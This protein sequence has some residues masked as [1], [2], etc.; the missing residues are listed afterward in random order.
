MSERADAGLAFMLKYENIAWY[1]G[2]AVK[3]LD[4]RVYPAR[5]EFVTCKTSGE[6]ARAIADMVTQSAGPYA[7]AGMG[8]A[9]AAYEARGKG[10]AEFNSHLEKAAH[11]LSHARPTTTGRMLAV[12]GGCLD[13]AK[14]ARASG[15]SVDEA[16]RDYTVMMND[17]RYNKIGATAK[18]LVDMFPKNGVVMTQCFGETIVGKM[19]LEA[20]AR[21]NDI[22][23]ICPETRPYFQGAHG[24]NR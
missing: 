17:L 7:A 12:T 8:M 15:K 18:Y 9:L 16:I 11:T 19:L 22:K 4:R 5:V 20:R 10:E 21:G 2:G 14:K 23:L 24:H 3:I 1:D 6:V 13:A